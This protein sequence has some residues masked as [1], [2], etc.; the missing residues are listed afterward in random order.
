MLLLSFS[1]T[2]SPVSWLMMSTQSFWYG[3]LFPLN[4]VMGGVEPLE[5][6][7][8]NKHN[9]HTHRHRKILSIWRGKNGC[10]LS[11][12]CFFFVTADLLITGPLFV[13]IQLHTRAPM[14][15][16]NQHQHA[17]KGVWVFRR[18]MFCPAF[19]PLRSR[20]AQITG[21][22][23]NVMVTSSP[24]PTCSSPSQLVSIDAGLKSS[25]KEEHNND[26]ES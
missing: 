4:T 26:T 8:V 17:G 10:F 5:G 22:W 13:N 16:L 7:R 3:R 6:N 18:E 1:S 14:H 24:F 2:N 19:V 11:L 25:E 15:I 12:Q 9:L 20:R 23:G 21:M